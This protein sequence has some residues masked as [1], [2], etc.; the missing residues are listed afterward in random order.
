LA[1]VHISVRHH[2]GDLGHGIMVYGSY[3]VGGDVNVRLRELLD[4]RT[5]LYAVKQLL[6]AN[7]VVAEPIDR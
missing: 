3:I 7:F 4:K 1:A 6:N 5:V 2:F